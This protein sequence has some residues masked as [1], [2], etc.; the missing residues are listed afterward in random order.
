MSDGDVL[1]EPVFETVMGDRSH[2]DLFVDHG[3]RFAFATEAA[4]IGY[5]FC[6]LPFDKLIWDERVKDHFW[7]SRGAEVDIHLFYARLHP[8]DR[9]RTRKAIDLAINTRT[10]Y[11][12]EYRTVS[13]EG[14]IKWI[15]A[16]GRT[17]YD[18]AGQPIRFDG[19]TREITSLREAEAARDRA[20]EALLRSEKLA[21]VGRLAATIA[22]EINN[23][24]AA[25]IN[26]LYLIE[27]STTDPSM[28]AYV[29][30]AM[31]EVNRIS[32]IV[33]HTLRFNRGSDLWSWDRAS[34]I[35]DS[36]L[37]LY[38]SRLRQSGIELRR[39]YADADRLFCH[40]SGLRQVFA[41]LVANAIDAMQGEKRLIVR[42]RQQSHSRTGEM[43][44]RVIIADTGHGMKPETVR[45][46]FKPFVST[47]GDQGTGL[48]LWVSHEIL[49]K[50]HA[51]I[52]VRSHQ[53]PGASG[54]VFSIW[55]PQ[56]ETKN[57]ADPDGARPWATP[58]SL[59]G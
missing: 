31:E 1:P 49:D 38:D 4:Q 48:G 27:Q 36:A 56:T 54:S 24:L 22:H 11:D 21:L 25:V 13:P 18:A 37:A 35:V 30:Q 33:G 47:K 59:R 44:I 29:K 53:T 50:H 16:I 23:P 6:N 51:T 46:L 17:A 42:I 41:N 58:D 26:L 3:D 9:E 45:E 34:H 19:V 43:G 28:L 52:R 5:W 20:K 2:I 55:I 57:S 40:P 7:L 8:D 32:H 14:R 39:D 10:Q 15:R 12:I